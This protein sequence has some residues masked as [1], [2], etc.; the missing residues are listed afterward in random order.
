M[1]NSPGLR[2]RSRRDRIR[3][4]ASEIPL[5]TNRSVF[6]SI[7]SINVFEAQVF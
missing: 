5:S 3:L 1:D 4:V 2:P 7:G 6:D